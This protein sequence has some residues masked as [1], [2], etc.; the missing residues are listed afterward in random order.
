MTPSPLSFPGAA[1]NSSSTRKNIPTKPCW[2]K[3]LL[4]SSCMGRQSSPALLKGPS[5]LTQS[6]LLCTAPTAVLTAGRSTEVPSQSWRLVQLTV[7]LLWALPGRTC[8]NLPRT[9]AHQPC[10]RP[11]A[12]SQAAPPHPGMEELCPSTRYQP[13]LVLHRGWFLFYLL[14]FK[15]KIDEK[16]QNRHC[17]SFSILDFICQGPKRDLV[18]KQ[19]AGRWKVN[20]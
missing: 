3:Y 1:G 10:H 12:S 9:C 11:S 4:L 16:H 8:A 18:A 17:V 7:L 14:I 2:S 15:E 5:E 13:E 20:P 19:R 6:V